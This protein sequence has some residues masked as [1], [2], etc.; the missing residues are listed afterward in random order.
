M[1]GNIK[2][3]DEHI[4]LSQQLTALQRRFVL[5]IVSKG[6]TQRQAYVKSGG[7]AKTEDSQDNCASQMFSKLQVKAFHDSLIK[8]AVTEAVSN[9]VDALEVLVE[10]MNDKEEKAGD[11]ISSI[12]TQS[13]LNGWDAPKETKITGSLDVGTI[14]RTIVKANEKS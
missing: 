3:T 9:K 7:R 6:M 1:A 12:R 8:A 14:T 13:A 10:I 11:R 2:L 5:N 4:K